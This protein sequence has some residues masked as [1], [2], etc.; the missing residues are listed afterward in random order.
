[1]LC[2]NRQPGKQY[3]RGAI[4]DHQISFGLFLDGVSFAA[5]EAGGGLGVVLAAALQNEEADAL[6]NQ[7]Y[8]AFD[9]V[10]RCRFDV[11]KFEGIVLIQVLAAGQDLYEEI[12]Q[13]R[14]GRELLVQQ[15]RTKV[16]RTNGLKDSHPWG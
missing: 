4:A 7:C 6:T 9:P 5:T 12:G 2:G 14:A 15:R 1:M 11:A 13:T 8:T 16:R 10:K 3:G